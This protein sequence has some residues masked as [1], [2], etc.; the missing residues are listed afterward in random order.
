MQ[1]WGRFPMDTKALAFPQ[2][3]PLNFNFILSSSIQYLEKVK[4]L[5]K[6]TLSRDL[7]SVPHSL[8]FMR[9]K[10][11]FSSHANWRLFFSYLSF[12]C[13]SFCFSWV[14]LGVNQATR[15]RYFC[16]PPSFCG[17]ECDWGGGS[18]SPTA[19]LSPGSHQSSTSCGDFKAFP[20]L[21]FSV[22]QWKR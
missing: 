7:F 17:H 2:P 8:K 3:L 18:G 10:L 14:C 4:F 16:C 9:L 15:S 5:L 22:P 20:C 1:P 13:S 21:F 19:I 12:F 11:N 6:S